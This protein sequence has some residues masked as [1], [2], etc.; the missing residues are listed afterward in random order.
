MKQKF[1]REAS[2]PHTQPPPSNQI[3]IEKNLSHI[4]NCIRL[5]MGGK[6]AKERRRLERMD[7]Q[8]DAGVASMEAK[9]AKQAQASRTNYRK[10]EAPRGTFQKNGA[11]FDRKNQGKVVPKGKNP[12]K[13]KFDRK[14]KVEEPPKKKA[15]K[16]PKHLKRKLEQTEDGTVKEEVLGE[17]QKLEERKKL[18]S[19]QMPST[20]PKTQKKTPQKKTPQK[21]DTKKKD[22]KSPAL[23]DKREEPTNKKQKTETIQK[24]VKPAGSSVVRR[25]EPNNKQKIQRTPET[26]QKPEKST[27]PAALVRKEE[28]SMKQKTPVKTPQKTPQKTVTNKKDVKSA[29][30]KKQNAEKKQNDEETT[31]APVLVREEEPSSV[32]APA[33]AKEEKTSSVVVEEGAD[34]VETKKTKQK[35]NDTGDSDDNDD[36]DDDMDEPVKR[37]RGRGRKGRQDTEALVKE[38]T[39]I[40]RKAL[41]AEKRAKA[42]P[43]DLSRRCIGRKAITDFVIGQCYPGKVVYIKPFG[44]FIDINCHSEMFCH[45]SRVQD[46]FIKSPEEALAAGD[47]V[48]PRIVEIDEN[49]CELAIR[50]K[51]R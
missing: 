22:V 10:N 51:S 30:P 20:K 2:V 4:F 14:T 33:L 21:S 3:Y 44:V 48:N 45:V 16:K 50:R 23:L 11:G 7:M 46:G 6:A 31:E 42:V 24:D 27:E 41:E 34:V 18:F 28:P 32:E 12:T 37:Q 49:H 19:V 36:S 39:D 9:E 40:E 38:T 29:E 47:E 15:F 5:T 8:G 17:I 13:G 1:L 43:K 25:E 26:K 35:T